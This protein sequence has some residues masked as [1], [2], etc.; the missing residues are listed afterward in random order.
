MSAANPRNRVADSFH[1]ACLV[2]DWH[3]WLG[4]GRGLPVELAIQLLLLLILLPLQ[5]VLQLQQLILL[6]QCIA[7][8]RDDDLRGRRLKPG[9]RGRQQGTCKNGQTKHPVGSRAKN[10]PPNIVQPANGAMAK[11]DAGHGSS[12]F[13]YRGSG[14]RGRRRQFRSATSPV[15]AFTGGPA[16]SSLPGDRTALRRCRES[17]RQPGIALDGSH[18]FAALSG[19][20]R[21]R[22]RW[23][24]RR[25]P[26]DQVQRRLRR[27]GQAEC[28]QRVPEA[29]LPADAGRRRE[30]I[31]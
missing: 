29:Q 22:A 13:I 24:Q 12:M 8:R 4:L 16:S 17:A 7:V 14:A 6:H 31:S 10:H 18:R 15:S 25:R 3:I 19:R 1:S 23:R 27:N 11:R 26:G 5:P 21:A 28:G 9:N 2:I 20:R 30:G